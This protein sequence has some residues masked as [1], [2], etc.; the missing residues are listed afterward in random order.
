MKYH[1]GLLELEI[2]A[3]S[4]L[5]IKELIHG[6]FGRTSPNLKDVVGCNVDV[7]E[8]DVIGVDDE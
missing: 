2:S 8:L 7:V 4:G 6:D 1:D 3:E 5:Y